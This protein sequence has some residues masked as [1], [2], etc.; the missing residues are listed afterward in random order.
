MVEIYYPALHF[1]ILDDENTVYDKNLQVLT[2]PNYKKMMLSNYKSIVT[3]LFSRSLSKHIFQ[4]FQF[5]SQQFYDDPNFAKLALNYIQTQYSQITFV[6]LVN[7]YKT[8]TKTSYSNNFDAVQNWMEYRD[9]FS[10]QMWPGLLLFTTLTKE[11]QTKVLELYG[12]ST[13]IDESQFVNKIMSLTRQQELNSTAYA[14]TSNK[15]SPSHPPSPCP[16][17]KGNHWKRDCPKKH[18]KKESKKHAYLSSKVSNVSNT[19]SDIHDSHFANLAITESSEP[20]TSNDSYHN[21][22]LAAKSSPGSNNRDWYI[23]SGCTDHLI[24]DFSSFKDYTPMKGSDIQGIAGSVPIEG[25]GTA[26]KWGYTIKNASYA[27]DLPCNLL[28][29][30]RMTTTSGEAVIFTDSKVYTITITPQILDSAYCIGERSNGL[31]RLLPHSR[32]SA[33]CSWT[34][35]LNDVPASSSTPTPST[36]DQLTPTHDT[37]SSASIN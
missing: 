19:N 23:D 13:T 3:N 10:N 29:V 11:V 22:F 21:A 36:P 8:F 5:N 15:F 25:K 28:S 33:F 37:S 1:H 12:D 18:Y 35:D 30:A 27:P 14:A 24:S 16:L 9:V 20:N 7:T 2:H 31:Y 34:V 6:H 17:C 26:T 32:P 4:T